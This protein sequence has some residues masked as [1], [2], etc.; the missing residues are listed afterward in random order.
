MFRIISNTTNLRSFYRR[1]VKK[2]PENYVKFY[3]NYTE[4]AGELKVV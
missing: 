1:M 4:L 3:K 2:V